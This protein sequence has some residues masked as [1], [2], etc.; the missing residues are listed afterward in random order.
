MNFQSIVFVAVTFNYARKGLGEILNRLKSRHAHK[1]VVILG[2]V[3]IYVQLIL[4]AVVYK[5]SCTVDT[6]SRR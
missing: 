1:V 5:Y 4:R 6:D 3:C 2:T